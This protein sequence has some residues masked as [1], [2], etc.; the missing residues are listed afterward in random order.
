MEPVEIIRPPREAI[1]GPR[2]LYR[3]R[4]PHGGNRSLASP[5][6]EARIAVY[7]ARAARGEDLFGPEVNMEREKVHVA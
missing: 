4:C 6:V 2:P 1:E 3:Q 7:A 5:E